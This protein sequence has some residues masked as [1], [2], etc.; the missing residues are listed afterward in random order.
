[1][2]DDRR[3]DYPANVYIRRP[4]YCAYSVTHRHYF[5]WLE[6][7]AKLLPQLVEEGVKE[8]YVQS[9]WNYIDVFSTW[10]INTPSRS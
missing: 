9:F 5:R 10:M 3:E 4:S 7:Y 1:V 2:T 6:F 8:E